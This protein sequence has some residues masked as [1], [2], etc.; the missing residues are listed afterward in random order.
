MPESYLSLPAADRAQ[1][2]RT[3]APQIGK[4][5]A[6]LEK[7]VWV[8]WVL[9]HLFTMPGRHTMAFKGGTSLSK[10]YRAI[11][12]FSEDIDVTVDYRSLAGTAD[13]FQEGLSRRQQNK[14]S[15]ALIEQIRIHSVDVIAPYFE[16]ALAEQFPH[17]R[18][19]VERGEGG[20][21]ENLGIHY[22]S[23]AD[24]YDDYLADRVL[25]EPGGRNITEPNAIHRVRPDIADYLEGLHFPAAEVSVLAGE[26]TFWEKATLIHVECNRGTYKAGA[27]RLSRHWYDLACLANHAIGENALKD[28]A[29]LADVVKYKKVFFNNAY[30]GYEAC[31]EGNLR[32][33]P[34]EATLSSLNEDYASMIRAGMF[35]VAPPPFSEIVARLR[36]LEQRINELPQG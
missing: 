30:A 19:W 23:V 35:A 36:V 25:L 6:A 20:V 1:I 4:S 9:E 12:R 17:E 24:G 16:Q 15:D 26:R 21:P 5:P 28:R 11:E 8:C 27:D 33:I 13:P 18:V 7:D 34:T 10:V 31:L 14:I 29:L 2:L 3:V 22:T 32:L